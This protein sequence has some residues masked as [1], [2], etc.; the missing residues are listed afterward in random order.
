MG[1]AFTRFKMDTAGFSAEKSKRFALAGFTDFPT[2]W[3]LTGNYGVEVASRQGV[4]SD[5]WE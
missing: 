5:E 3:L 1:Q 4:R 2:C